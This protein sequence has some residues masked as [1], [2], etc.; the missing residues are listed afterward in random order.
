MKNILMS[1]LYDN[2]AC[3][4]LYV[5]MIAYW[6]VVVCDLPVVS[7]C[8]GVGFWRWVKTQRTLLLRR[9]LLSNSQTTVPC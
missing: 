5:T 2:C 6:L 8:S 3:V 7:T 4:V 9:L 1:T